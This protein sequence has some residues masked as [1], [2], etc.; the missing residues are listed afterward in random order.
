MNVHQLLP[1]F[2]LALNALLLV[3]ALSSDRQSRRHRIFAG[4]VG[5]LAV[6]NLGV[7]GLR[8]S[9]TA[10]AAL[11]WE[12]FLHVGVILCPV[13][14]CHYVRAF[15]DQ[16][17]TDR[18]LQAGYL[19]CGLFLVASPT[20]AFMQGVLST[21]WGYVP[22][23]GALYSPFFLYF[24]VFVVLG[25]VRLL[26]ARRAL[27]S[28]VS[29]TRANL[30]IAGVAVS[31][32]GGLVD[33][34]R[35]L[36]GWE[37][38]Y[39]LGIPCN[40]LFALALGLGIVRYRL[41]D[42]G[43]MTRWALLYLLTGAT[44]APVL[45]GGLF[46]ARTIAPD[47]LGAHPDA[48]LIIAVLAAAVMLPMLRR[49][50]RRLERVMFAREH[51]VRDAL[52]ALSRQLASTLDLE[53]LGR[54]L[55]DGLVAQ[56]PVI[57]ASLHLRSDE[58]SPFTVAAYATSS[59][60]ETPIAALGDLS[61]LGHHAGRGPISVDDLSPVPHDDNELRAS[62]ALLEAADVALVVP[63]F[64]EGRLSGLLLLGKKVSGSEFL[65]SEIG[66][67]EILASQTAIAL[68]N[69]T[70]Y[71]N[72]RRQMHS[73]REAQQQLI[74]S[75]KLAA[76]GEL[77]A[78]VAHEINNPLMIILGNCEML[79]LDLPAEARAQ[80]RLAIMKS[81]THRAGTITR[82]LL[83]LARRREPKR[84]PL[85]VNTVV[86]R[87]LELLAVKLRHMHVKVE[88][89]LD[90]EL[91][92]ILADADQLT[93]VLLN[94]GGNAVDAMPGGGT[95]RFETEWRRD[96]D[97][98]LVRAIDTGTGMTPEV[99]ARIFEPLFTT[100]PEGRGT[101]LGMSVSLGIIKD[102]DGTLDVQS[103]PGRGTTITIK[104]PAYV[105]REPARAAAE[106]PA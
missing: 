90:A 74:Q 70:L 100:K 86:H 104:L 45:V 95:L 54:T 99:M 22:L 68:E 36:L 67:F 30:V 38:L 64:T 85:A 76:V 71:S 83:S 39:P 98:I 62:L 77:A 21:A 101:G 8:V 48:D 19:L 34:V 2:A 57:H 78:S 79:S 92:A 23:A 58:R 93:Q 31:L 27:P 37:W 69:S 88:T 55:V 24:Q 56:V 65:A 12:R 13:L 17:D 87:T 72:L 102:H 42:L 33:F 7:F 89:A 49:L 14:F 28:R 96:A 26:R 20:P 59:Q 50:E 75:A 29:R 97:A 18:L 15:L 43:L 9:E 5:A 25:L 91:P 35:Y 47:F 73:L 61:A 52:M 51:G 3:S 94:V 44:L 6:W 63:L 84:E 4:L 53:F 105:V 103:E 10:T 41:L 66:L 46:A 106:S 1:L 82:N 81:E 11:A 32:L 80:E 60:A 16:R 40:A